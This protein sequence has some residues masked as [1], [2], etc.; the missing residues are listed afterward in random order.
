VSRLII[1]N[2]IVPRF[3]ANDFPGGI[4]RAS[5]TS[6][7]AHRRRRGVEAARGAAPRH[8]L[9]IALEQSDRSAGVIVVLIVVGYH[10]VLPVA[11]AFCEAVFQI[12]SVISAV[13][14][15]EA[16]AHRALLRRR[17]LVR[18]G[19]ASG[20]GEMTGARAILIA[21]ALVLGAALPRSRS[22]SPR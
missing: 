11:G 12:L 4:A 19:G 2:A 3:R 17:R 6:S 10:P 1:E 5:T 21:F 18:C 7:A 15:A 16:R 22:I 9:V 8:G 13:S 14:A 20:D